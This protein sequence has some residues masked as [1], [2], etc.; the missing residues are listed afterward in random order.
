MENY[1]IRLLSLLYFIPSCHPSSNYVQLLTALKRVA[2]SVPSTR[3]HCSQLNILRESNMLPSINAA[4]AVQHLES[5][6]SSHSNPGVTLIVDL[7]LNANANDPPKVFY[8]EN[9]Y[10][11]RHHQPCTVI[12]FEL[13]SELLDNVEL[14]NN[15]TVGRRWG[16]K[17]LPLLPNDVYRSFFIFF[18]PHFQEDASPFTKVNNFMHET[19]TFQYSVFVMPD[20]AV[21]ISIFRGV[22]KSSRELRVAAA[23]TNGSW[24]AG[25]TDFKLFTDDFD[26]E[27]KEIIT[28]F[29]V[30]CAPTEEELKTHDIIGNSFKVAW[31]LAYELFN[32]T[33]VI[34]NVLV[35]DKGLTEDGEFSDLVLPTMEGNAAVTGIMIPSIY[36]YHLVMFTFPYYYDSAAFIT[37]PPTV[38]SEGGIYMIEEPLHWLVWLAII[39]SSLGVFA[40]IDILFYIAN[41]RMINLQDHVWILQMVYKPMLEQAGFDPVQF[42]SR[43]K[44]YRIH[45]II[46]LWSLCL[47]V[48]GCAYDSAL[49]EVVAFP[50]LILPPQTF[51]ELAAASDYDIGI[52]F[53]E[54]II[55]DLKATNMTSNLIIA[56]RVTEHD[57]MEPTVSNNFLKNQLSLPVYVRGSV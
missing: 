22:P 20:S 33:P 14:L 25:S 19:G 30:V 45:F 17:I 28:L 47:I 39:F 51:R 11:Y 2:A 7:G 48:L 6:S 50:R 42:R 43:V 9:R 15:G 55:H 29:C 46:G 21:E 57:F 35:P 41:N 23:V 32:M 56:D 8:S 49:L 18:L 37:G 36:T 31:I 13:I 10:F 54:T 44:L 3:L 16:E 27:G 53:G 38:L 24:T 34:E 1:I 26:F 4:L 52:V 12:Y 5:P 40:C